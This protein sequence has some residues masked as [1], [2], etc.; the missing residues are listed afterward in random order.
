MTGLAQT[1]GAVPANLKLRK[2]EAGGGWKDTPF[3]APGMEANSAH[4]LA[5]AVGASVA[6]RLIA[7][8]TTKHEDEDDQKDYACLE[9]LDGKRFR[10][11]TPGQ[12]RYLLE[13]AKI[14]SRVVI[15]YKG[16]EKV[17]GYK[18]PLH[19]FEVSIIEGGLQ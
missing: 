3:F 8:R 12:L 7:L 10:I 9:G 19:Q 11:Q 18:Q 2:L 5:F 4:M 17:E 6:G 1:V 15:T 13:E 14:E 16:R